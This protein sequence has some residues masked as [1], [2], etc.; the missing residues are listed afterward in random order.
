MPK[1]ILFMLMLLILSTS[2]FASLEEIEAE[3]AEAQGKVIPGPLDRIFGNEHIN[4]YVTLDN[5]EEIIIGVIT[6]NKIIKSINI[7]K[8]ANPSLNV[9]TNE[10]TVTEILNAEARVPLIQQA[11]KEKK[12]RYKGVGFF[13]KLKFAF[14]GTVYKVVTFFSRPKAPKPAEILK[15]NVC[16]PACNLWETCLQ[17]KC[18]SDDQ[19]AQESDEILEI[20]PCGNGVIDSGELCDDG[21]HCEDGTPCTPLKKECKGIGDGSCKKRNS[22]GCDTLCHQEVC[23]NGHIQPWIGEA[24][25]DG[26]KN[27]DDDCNSKCQF[28]CATPPSNLVSWWPGD[29]DAKDIQDGNHGK[30]I[31]GTT[32]TTGKVGLA[33]SFDGDND[34]VD[35]PLPTIPTKFTIG[36]WVRGSSFQGSI[37]SRV[38]PIISQL[39]AP[40]SWQFT[41]E[42][43]LF[44]AAGALKFQYDDGSVYSTARAAIGLGGAIPPEVSKKLLPNQ[45]IVLR[46]DEWEHVAVSF[47]RSKLEIA[48]QIKFYINGL[49]VPI[50][51]SGTSDP[52]PEAHSVF[53]NRLAIGASLFDLSGFPPG[54]FEDEMTADSNSI[55][56]D[57]GIDEVELFDRILSPQEIADIFNAG[58]HGKC[59]P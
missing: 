51:I 23:G 31:G 36:A 30:L 41:V 46:E 34:F 20:D 57:G 25:D 50:G 21:I 54:K 22:D 37:G 13:N 15:L 59:K 52:Q 24:C 32:F 7:S 27:E 43:Q 28:T 17:G 40:F 56:W 16:S 44:V 19:V 33:F 45:H 1:K 58:S 14:T 8:L 35:V 5:N 10:T 49:E 4:I 29:N 9:Y 26:N 3:T 55:F 12:I 53:L 6:E 47:D 39:T 2:A 18:V 38:L 11:L 48:E 42:P